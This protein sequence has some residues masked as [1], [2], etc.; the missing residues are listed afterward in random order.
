MKNKKK[1]VTKKPL[2]YGVSKEMGLGFYF[3]PIDISGGILQKGENYQDG[4]DK[5]WENEEFWKGS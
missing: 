1:R 3:D 2:I 4:S 5:Y